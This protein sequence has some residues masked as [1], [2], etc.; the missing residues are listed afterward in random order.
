LRQVWK[1]AVLGRP[2]HLSGLQSC[3]DSVVGFD[4]DPSPEVEVELVTI[5]SP[6]LSPSVVLVSSV[7]LD[8]PTV[9]DAPVVGVTVD[10]VSG[11]TVDPSWVSSLEFES[12]PVVE[13]SVVV[14]T[15]ESVSG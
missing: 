7:V 2:A 9:V 11:S 8:I 3:S 6:V 13:A 4:V 10:P 1:K 5:K 15:P 12:S 14:D